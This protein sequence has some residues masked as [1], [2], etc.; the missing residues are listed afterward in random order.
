MPIPHQ[1]RASRLFKLFRLPAILSPSRVA[2]HVSWAKP[3]T[4]HLRRVCNWRH[5]NFARLGE[6]DVLLDAAKHQIRAIR[7]SSREQQALLPWIGT[8]HSEV[9]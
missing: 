3:T 2:G 6:D 4:T 9:W 1:L 5:F 8:I 7:V